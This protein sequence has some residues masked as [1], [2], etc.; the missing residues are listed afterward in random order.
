MKAEILWV[1][2]WRDLGHEGVCGLYHIGVFI[3]YL[4]RFGCAEISSIEYVS[5]YEE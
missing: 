3:S 5:K 1:C 2:S 4:S